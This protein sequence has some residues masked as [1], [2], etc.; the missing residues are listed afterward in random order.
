MGGLRSSLIRHRVYRIALGGIL[1]MLTSAASAQGPAPE[2]GPTLFP[3]GG[4]VS[5]GADFFSRKAPA[6]GTGA[7]PLTIR[8]TLEVSQPLVFGW[9]VRRDIELMAITSIGTARLRL[10]GPTNEIRAGGTGWGDS[11]VLVKYRFL[12]QDSKRGTTQVSVMLGPKLPTGRT[13]LRDAAGALLPVSLQPGSGSTDFFVNL[14]GTY[15][16][17]FSVE[18]LV[19]D[20]AVDYLR[21]S[22]GAER[23]RLGNSLRARLYVPYRPYQSHSVGKEFWIGPELIWEQRGYDRIGSL[24]QANSGGDAL[25]LGGA[26]YYSPYPGLELWFGVDLAVA[27]HWN[28]IQD[29]FKRHISMGISKQFEFHRQQ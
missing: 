16:G 14:S 11:W 10:P 17:L 13:N 26:T 21:R 9:G 19:A 22:E 3:G 7:I 18:K 4:V 25:R 8:P 20:G 29:T 12:R 23:T 6:S 28:G 5:Y 1:G 27:Q 15:T 24:R 2:T